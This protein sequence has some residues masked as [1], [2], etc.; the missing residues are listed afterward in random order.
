MKLY[1]VSSRFRLI[2][3][4]LLK[5]NHC[6]YQFCCRFPGDIAVFHKTVDKAAFRSLSKFFRYGELD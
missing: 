6:C 2:L 1:G 3:I 4:D 5:L